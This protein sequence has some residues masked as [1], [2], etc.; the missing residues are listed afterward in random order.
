MHDNSG[1][2]RVRQLKVHVNGC[3]TVDLLTE[4]EITKRP[5]NIITEYNCKDRNMSGYFYLQCVVSGPTSET[6]QFSLTP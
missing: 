6:I 3:V 1:N 2:D 4:N 5:H